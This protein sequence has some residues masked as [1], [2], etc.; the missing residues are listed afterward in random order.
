MKN[1]LFSV[2]LLHYNQ[3]RYIF[4]ALDSVLNQNYD[5]IELVIADDASTDIDLDTLK[6]YLEE[7]KKDNI[8]NIIY[9]INEV[10]QG[11]VKTINSAVKKCNGKYILF[12][13]ADDALYDEN[14]I[15][16][17][18][19]SFR[20]SK[21]N[22][23]MISSQCHMMDENLEEELHTFVRPTQAVSFNK[24]NSE[25]QYRVFCS[26]CF[27][28]IGATAM[29]SNM[30]EKFG[31]F[32][33]EYKFIEDWSYFLHLTRNGGLM[34]YVD[35]NGL[36]HR[37]GGVS[38][39]IDTKNVPPHVMAYKYDMIKIFENEILP[40]LKRFDA[41][42]IIN[43]LNWY[44]DEKNSYY[45]L[46]GT[47]IS[48]SKFKLFKMFPSFYTQSTLFPITHDWS[49]LINPAK[50]AAIV[51]IIYIT[52]LFISKS[53]PSPIDIVFEYI[54]YLFA[55][56]FTIILVLMLGICAIKIGVSFLQKIKRIL[57]GVN[58]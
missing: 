49:G 50:A 2:I 7:N 33:E 31:Y 29:R 11:T 22:V 10:N 46:G 4:T 48:L 44:S 17:F 54:G 18:E 27:L 52:A 51:G 8:A 43:T 25:E 56:I 6:S 37:D 28:A 14:V 40:Y 35:F 39:Y 55:L 30:F 36:L 16:N 57:K 41:A 20:K 15:S 32:N 24:M 53:I 42:T 38:H 58:R 47:G 45:S 5:N 26:S 3:P 1:D 13:A 21:D 34:K 23:Y 19:K 9:S 12:F